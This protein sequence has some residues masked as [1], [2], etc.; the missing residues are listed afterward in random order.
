[1]NIG[2]NVVQKI[3]RVSKS[4]TEGDL[5]DSIDQRQSSNVGVT[6]TRT[7]SRSQAHNDLQSLAK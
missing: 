7:L 3:S 4:A 5:I 2:K 6:R 1:M